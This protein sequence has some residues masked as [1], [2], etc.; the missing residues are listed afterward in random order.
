MTAMTVYEGKL[1]RV[2]KSTLD[3]IANDLT[4]RYSPIRIKELF[5]NALVNKSLLVG[6]FTKQ[7]VFEV[8]AYESTHG[9][10]PNFLQLLEYVTNPMQFGE[11][12]DKANRILRLYIDLLGKENFQYDHGRWYVGPSEQEI[13][14]GQHDYWRDSDGKILEPKISKTVETNQLVTRSSDGRD[15]FYN[16]E[17]IK[18]NHTHDIYKAFNVLYQSVNEA[19]FVSYDQYEKKFKALYKV[20]YKKFKDRDFRSWVLNKLTQNT[21]GIKKKT[22][23]INLVLPVRGKGLQFNNSKLP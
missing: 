17:K 10:I 6:K 14:L 21:E 18:W 8:L 5:S 3:L 7:K 16:N 15:F 9:N 12:E 23:D 22:G 11:N 19:G 2:S 1:Q 13:L 20:E 4:K